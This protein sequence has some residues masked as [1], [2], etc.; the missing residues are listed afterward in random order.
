MSQRQ[1]YPDWP[2]G[3]IDEPTVCKEK[4]ATRQ[5][6]AEASDINFIMKRYEKTGVLPVATREALF[7]DVSNFGTFH[8]A[9]QH[10]EEARSAFDALPPKVRARFQNDPVA[11]VDFCSTPGNR[12]ELVQLG[13]VEETA[14]QPV[15]APQAAPGAQS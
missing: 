2:F 5:S 11:F 8:E 13:L 4:S 14:A 15:V 7:M 12:D 10:V 6:E 3:A 9:L 1:L